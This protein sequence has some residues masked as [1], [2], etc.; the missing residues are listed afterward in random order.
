MYEFI[1]TTEEQNIGIVTL[2]R[3]ETLNAWHK[4]MRDE[5]IDALK[6]YENNQNI[7]AT[8]LT[9][10]GDRGFCAGQDLAEEQR[11]GWRNGTSYMI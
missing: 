6:N 11:P 5:L 4:P 7:R 10:A 1:K 2:N 8:I 9:G 3:L